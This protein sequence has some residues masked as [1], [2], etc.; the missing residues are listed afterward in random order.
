MNR[1]RSDQRLPDW[2]RSTVRH[3]PGPNDP[4]RHISYHEELTEEAVIDGTKRLLRAH[5]RHHPGIML[6]AKA[7]GRQVV[8]P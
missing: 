4:G 2:M 7:K 8:K 6:V 3:K 1:Y 5:W